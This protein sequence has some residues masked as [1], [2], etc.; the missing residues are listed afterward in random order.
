M[1][2]NNKSTDDSLFDKSTPIGFKDK[3]TPIGL[4][5]EGSET[6]P[7]E[8]EEVSNSGE[9]TPEEQPE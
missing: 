5:E 7:V 1:A 9:N 3:S 6:S 2:T 8:A 4:A